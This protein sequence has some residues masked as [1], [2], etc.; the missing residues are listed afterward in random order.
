MHFRK[1]W[2]QRG[3]LKTSATP[4]EKPLVQP[5]RVGMRW[6]IPHEPDVAR[7]SIA[8]ISGSGSDNATTPE[9]GN[10]AESSSPEREG[11]PSDA[12][13]DIR[14]SGGV[15]KE[16]GGVPHSVEAPVRTNGTPPAAE[17]LRGEELHLGKPSP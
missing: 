13:I 9:G 14:S 5:R 7:E 4:P 11:S 15:P 3:A 8:V 17:C 1:E 2:H 6:R 16:M 12:A 10:A